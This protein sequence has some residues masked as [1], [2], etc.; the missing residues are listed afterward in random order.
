MALNVDAELHMMATVTE[1]Q[2]SSLGISE[3]LYLPA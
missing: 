2:Q 3:E 1:H